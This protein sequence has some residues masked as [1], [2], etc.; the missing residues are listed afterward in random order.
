MGLANPR[1]TH[2]RGTGLLLSRSSLAPCRCVLRK[3][4]RRCYDRFHV[5][6]QK[7]ASCSRTSLEFTAGCDRRFS[8]GRKD[9]EFI[10]DFL[11]V[12]KRSLTGN[13]YQIF[14]YHYLLGADWKLC[15]RRLNLERGSFFHEVY[16]IEEKLGRIFRELKPYSLFPLDEYFFGSTGEMDQRVHALPA[17][18]PS[19]GLKPGQRIPIPVRKAA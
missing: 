11:L 9:E 16:R 17:F 19:R 12:S 7:G 14:S 8:W 3:I 18:A 1:C 10:A 4:F 5:S 15:C 2:C 6:M 13:E